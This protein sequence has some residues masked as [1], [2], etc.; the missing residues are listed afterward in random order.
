M[1]S[2]TQNYQQPPKTQPNKFRLQDLSLAEKIVYWTIVLTPLWWLLGIQTLLYPAVIVGLLLVNLNFDKLIKINIPIA[3][4][5]WL[6]MAMTMLWTALFGLSRNNFDLIE[7]ASTLVTFF[8][9]YFLIFACLLLPFV[10]SIRVKVIARAVAWMTLGYLVLIVLQL[11]LMILG[12]QL[13]PFLPPLAKLT[14]GNSLSLVVKLTASQQA[15]FGITVPRSALYMPD[16]PI[17][18]ICGLLA[19]IICWG[20]SNPR[21]RYAACAGSLSAILISQ[22]RLAWICLP[23]AIMVNITFLNFWARQLSL[24]LFT[25]T[26]LLSSLFELTI[27]KLLQKPWEIF[28]KARPASTT[29]REF[30]VRKTLEAWQES[31]WLGWGVVHDTANWY[32]YKLPL[33]SFSTYASVLYLHGTIGFI[34]F[35]ATLGITL[36]CFGER[37]FEGS[38]LCKRAF[39]ALVVLYLFIQGLPLSWFAVYIWFFFIWLGAILAGSNRNHQRISQWNYLH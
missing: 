17:P 6:A 25:L 15:F 5:A 32:T 27:G 4:W 33:G 34:V 19:L 38:I 10:T 22:S 18:G 11:T 26:A 37:A 8:K 31:P 24:W 3:V 21:L 14:P 23:I 39:A 16:P 7:V 35:I 30:V 20:E 36:V 13:A 1:Y 9:G 29:D 2:L 12:I 28:D